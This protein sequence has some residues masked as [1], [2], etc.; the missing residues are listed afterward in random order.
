MVDQSGGSHRE[1]EPGVHGLAFVLELT[2]RK[3]AE[4]GA[5]QSERRY[6]EVQ[7]ELAHATAWPPWAKSLRQ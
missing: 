5:R 3:R 4:A 2:E 7:I 6:R 1:D